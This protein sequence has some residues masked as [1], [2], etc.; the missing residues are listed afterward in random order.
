MSGLAPGVCPHLKYETECE[1]CSRWKEMLAS[2]AQPTPRPS[3]R[4]EPTTESVASLLARVRGCARQGVYIPSDVEE[5][6]LRLESLLFGE[7][8]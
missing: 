7:S 2:I 6:A 5:I 4:P 8:K 1:I 3:T